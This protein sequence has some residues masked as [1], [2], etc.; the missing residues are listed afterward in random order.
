MPKKSKAQQS[1]EIAKHTKEYL[2]RGGRITQVPEGE[3]T[4]PPHKVTILQQP[5]TARG[6]DENTHISFIENTED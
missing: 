2:D 6:Y 1:A 5:R 4:L 3:F